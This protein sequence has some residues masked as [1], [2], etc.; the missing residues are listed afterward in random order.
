MKKIA[1]ILLIMSAS[2][3]A[4]TR[5]TP[6][7][8]S[9]NG[10]SITFS[11]DLK[12]VSFG[13]FEN[14]LLIQDGIIHKY[15]GT[16]NPSKSFCEINIACTSI[17]N[18]SSE[19]VNKDRNILFG[20]EFAQIRSGVSDVSGQFL[21]YALPSGNEIELHCHTNLNGDV[22]EGIPS[23]NDVESVLNGIIK[24]SP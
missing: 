10:S 13:F 1:I 17:A 5:E 11:K 24:F 15:Y 9:P 4:Q 14:S 8:A 7:P 2:A 18:C 16:L 22:P 21:D 12:N 20:A 3:L 23:M 19:I 6:M